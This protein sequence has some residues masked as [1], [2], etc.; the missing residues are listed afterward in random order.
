MGSPPP[1]SV[2]EATGAPL[3]IVFMGTPALAAHILER[4]IAAAGT[5]FLV[6]GVITRPDQP[7]KRG[8]KMEPSEVGAVSERA[9]LPTLKPVKIRT[10]EFLAE[11][12]S[13]APDLL[14]VAAYG[15]I[16]PNPVLEAPR[17]IPINVHVSLLPRHRGAA[18]I[19]GAILAGD[20]ESGVTIMR[21]IERMDAGPILLQRAI[22]LAPDETQG[23]LK[24]KLAELGAQALL[25][26]IAQFRSGSIV[27]TAQDESLATYTAPIEKA[28]SVIDW[29]GDAAHIER[30]VRAH[31]PWPVAR[32]TIGGEDLWIWRARVIDDRTADQ[33]D[34][35]YSP[36]SKAVS[37]VGARDVIGAVDPAANEPRGAAQRAAIRARRDEAHGGIAAPGTITELKPNPVVKCRTGSLALIEVQAAGRRRMAAADYLRGRRVVVGTR[38]GG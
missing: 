11:L 23:T 27:E 31:D 5:D 15:R 36:G 14:V 29:N 3:R 7:R 6:A 9:G 4:M 8:L 24:E 22:P 34:G 13:F 30:M 32:T 16:L 12:K 21:V 25:E 37:A 26:A 38:L 19:E 10:P 2:S 18:P 1:P 35:G 20:R 28:R 17:L 33:F